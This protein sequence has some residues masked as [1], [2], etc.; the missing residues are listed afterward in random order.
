[1]QNINGE[2][3]NDKREYISILPSDC[4]IYKAQY[5]IVYPQQMLP[6]PASKSDPK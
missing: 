5:Q 2:L 6:V 3:I 4:K 1:M